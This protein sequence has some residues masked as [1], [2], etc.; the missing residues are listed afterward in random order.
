MNL[1]ETL[2]NKYSI[3]VLVDVLMMVLLIANLTLILFD[4]VFAISQVGNFFSEYTPDFYSFYNSGIHQNFHSIDMLFVMIFL[5]EFMFSWILAVIQK[6]YYKWFFYPIVHWY[7]LIGC[8]P[9]GSLRFLRILRV[10]SILVRLQNLKVIDLSNSYIATKLK[11][12]YGILVE[13]ISDRVVV[14]ILEGVQDEIT[15]GGQAMDNIF[16]KVIRPKQEQ[17]VEWVSRRIEHVI[18]KDVLSKK[19]E[20]NAYVHRLISESLKKNAELKTLDQIPIMGKMITETIENSISDAINNIIEQAL[21]DLS[22]YKNRSLVRETTDVI[23]N[24]L[25]Y[26]DQEG[27][28]NEIFTDISLEIIDIIK[29]QVRVKKWKMKEEAEKDSDA[30]EKEGIEF[31]MADN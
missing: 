6:V 27:E 7:D 2:K 1:R 4:W 16:K 18:D 19:E 23:L 28:L 15:G 8:I 3:L 13:E 21:E 20:I 5:S 17:I 30:A 10:F 9:V 12:Y 25:E 29:D 14:N 24:T 22:S 26:K 11:K 31:L